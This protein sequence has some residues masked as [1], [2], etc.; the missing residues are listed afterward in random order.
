MSWLAYKQLGNPLAPL[1]YGQHLGKIAS[2]EEQLLASPAE[3]QVIAGYRAQD[4]EARLQDVDAALERQ[5]QATQERIHRLRAQNADVGLI[6]AASRELAA[7]PRDAD[8]ARERWTRE[9]RENYARA[10]PLRGLPRQPGLRGRPRW[11]SARAGR[12]PR[13]PAQPSPSCSA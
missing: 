11:H 4:F 2:L 9:M 12:L 3:Q 10:Q 6:V 7:M 13:H 1:V 8:T 5:R